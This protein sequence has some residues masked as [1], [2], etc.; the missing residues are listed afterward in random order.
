MD[1]FFTLKGVSTNFSKL[2][3]LTLIHFLFILSGVSVAETN[4]ALN[5]NKNIKNNCEQIIDLEQG[6]LTGIAEASRAYNYCAYKG[7]PFAQPPVGDI[8]PTLRTLVL[9]GGKPYSLGIL[10]D[11]HFTL[12]LLGLADEVLAFLHLDLLATPSADQHSVRWHHY[13]FTIGT[14]LHQVTSTHSSY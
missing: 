6:Q 7:V 11:R 1:I 12:F 9:G 8:V 5:L 2:K 14:K 3:T 13:A 10:Y 4:T